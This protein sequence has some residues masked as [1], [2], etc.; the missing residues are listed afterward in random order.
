MVRVGTF[1]VLGITP[2]NQF[3]V[4]EINQFKIDYTFWMNLVF[5][6]VVGWLAWQNKT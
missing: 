4:S 1:D 2:E 5:I 3:A 6:W